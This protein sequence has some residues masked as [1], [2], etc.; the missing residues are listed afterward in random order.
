MEVFQNTS[1]PTLPIE[2]SSIDL[3][4]ALSVFTHIENFD[5]AW[6]MEVKRILRPGGIAWV[7]FHSEK[8]W[9]E[10]KPSLPIYKSCSRHPEFAKRRRNVHEQFDRLV[11]RWRGDHSYTSIVF[12]DTDFLCSRWGRVLDVLDVRR[13]VPTYQDVVILKKTL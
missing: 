11:F 5:L 10:M 3:I 6:I 9:V 12:Y 13:R 8:L 1:I 7:T 4:S 2:D